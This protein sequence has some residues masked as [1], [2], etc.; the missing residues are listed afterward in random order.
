MMTTPLEDLQMKKR[1]SGRY[2]THVLQFSPEQTKIL[3]EALGDEIYTNKMIEELE[4]KTGLSSVQI[5][6]WGHIRLRKKRKISVVDTVVDEVGENGGKIRTGSTEAQMIEPMTR[7]FSRQNLKFEI[8]S[9]QNYIE[10]ENN[11]D[12]EYVSDGHLQSSSS[13]PQNSE[14]FVFHA[15]VTHYLKFPS[16]FLRIF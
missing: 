10:T 1:G 9:T 8:R 3:T 13:S 16:K 5:R 11:V 6:N 2:R 4:K 14:N 15:E 12:D 7:E